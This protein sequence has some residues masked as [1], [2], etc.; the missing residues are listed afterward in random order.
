MVCYTLFSGSSGNCIYLEDGKTKIL[1]DAGGS[2]KQIDTALSSIGTS[3]CDISAIFVTHEHSDHTKGLPVICKNRGIPV[4][5]QS[6]VAKEMYL[7]LLQKGQQREA[8]SLAKCIRTVNTGEEYE[9]GDI[10]ITPFKTPHDSVNSQGFIIGDRVLGIATDLGHVSEEVSLFLTGCKNVI[11]ESNHDLEMLYNGPYPP[12][13]K[14]RVASDIGH[15]N[16]NDCAAFS[17]KLVE[18]GCENLTL[19]HLSQ[20]NN[21]PALAQKASEEALENLCGAKKGVD[22]TLSVADR[23][24]VKKIL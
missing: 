10:L 2:M 21:T 5:C 13:L 18:A 16:N 1:I 17:A 20:E 9:V 22:F 12:Y 7:S 23:F 3:L 15:L 14:E 8:A 19:F 6:E 24:E 11:L 4:Y